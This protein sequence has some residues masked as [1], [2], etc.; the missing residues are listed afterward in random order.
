MYG[1]L[2]RKRL[3]ALLAVNTGSFVSAASPATAED[4]ELIPASDNGCA[5]DLE[6]SVGGHDHQARIGTGDITITNLDNGATYLQRSRH[7]DTETFDPLTG[8]WNVTVRGNLWFPLYSGEPGP[9]GVVQQPGA[10]L[11]L[12]GKLR[13][14]VTSENVLTAFSFEGTYQDLCQLLGA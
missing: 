7:V 1:G 13:Y 9:S 3:F 6:V 5:V 12:S 8:N 14:T 10:E 11:L 4:S 2:T